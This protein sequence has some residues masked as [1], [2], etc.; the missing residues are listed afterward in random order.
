MGGGAGPEAKAAPFDPGTGQ[1][2]GLT[3]S[4]LSCSPSERF[5]EG[6][7]SLGAPPLA[8][9]QTPPVCPPF[10]LLSAPPPFSP[11]C[12]QQA[13][14]SPGC[15]QVG[16]E[17]SEPVLPPQPREGLSSLWFPEEVVLAHDG[18][19]EAHKALD[20]HGHQAP[21]HNVPLEGRLHLVKL[22]WGWG[23]EGGRSEPNWAHFPEGAGNGVETET[24]N[25]SA[26][27]PESHLSHVGSVSPAERA[28]AAAF[29][30]PTAGRGAQ[31]P[32]KS[33][34]PNRKALF[35]CSEALFI[36]ASCPRHRSGAKPPSGRR[37]RHVGGQ[38]AAGALR[39][40]KQLLYPG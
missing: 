19:E 26:P 11:K 40:S 13:E 20:G 9:L 6:N 16:N 25:S 1:D 7:V 38:E 30:P 23:G 37:Q 28:R 22:P 35:A 29:L 24:P 18:D 4:G 32:S 15:G 39:L 33:P 2:C 27:S 17:G 36:F 8:R 14:A 5:H 3:P 10:L 31:A 21:G 12:L 34:F